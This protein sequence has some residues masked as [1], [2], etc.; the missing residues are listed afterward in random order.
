MMQEHS[1]YELARRLGD[2]ESKNDDD[3]AKIL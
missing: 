2:E 3:L 1:D